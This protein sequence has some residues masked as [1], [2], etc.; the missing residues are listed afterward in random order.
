MP[1]CTSL[2]QWRTAN[3]PPQ[4][5]LMGELLST[6]SRL[7]LNGPTGRGKTMF[8]MAIT[9]ALSEG[10]D[11]LH[12]RAVRP[13]RVLYLDGEM[14]PNLMQR[15][16]EDSV[17]R[18]G[19]ID[20]PNN[21]H[22]VCLN[23]LSI[24]PPPLNT[25][26][27]QRYIDQVIEHFAEEW[28]LPD[29]AILDNVQALLVGDMKG[30]EPWHETMPW[31]YGLT[32]RRIG[33]FW[34]HH[35]GHDESRGYGTKTREWQLDTVMLL[36]PI[37]R[38]GADIAFELE[39]TKA[40]ERAPHNRADF[41]PMTITL[42]H[43]EWTAE[44][45]ETA[46]K[47]AQPAKPQKP[48]PPSP[49]AVKFHSALLDALAHGSERRQE[50]AGMPS[51]TAAQWE[52]E[53]ARLDLLPTLPPEGAAR[54]IQNRRIALISKYRTELIAADWIAANSGFLWSTRSRQE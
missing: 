46:N 21:A 5:F 45:V 51:V 12:W 43:D 8:L 33:Q 40:R 32:R 37:D 39:F 29:L 28:G 49:L 3:I 31:V 13:A 15:R 44:A 6:T 1:L 17:R 36:K 27:G 38:P 42:E 48:K 11:F 53:L 24:R 34:A 14:S 35:T 22:F 52:S 19:G 4:D 54:Q 23:Q 25:E 16:V 9:M 41:A 26:A 10:R 2:Y 18:A 20:H 50:A 7:L 47:A 30:E